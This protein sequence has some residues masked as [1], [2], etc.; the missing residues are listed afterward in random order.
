[1]ENQPPSKR[2]RLS[3]K[4][5]RDNISSSASTSVIS[6][7]E[8]VEHLAE[9]DSVICHAAQTEQSTERNIASSVCTGIADDVQVRMDL[10]AS[11]MKSDAINIDDKKDVFNGPVEHQK[12]FNWSGWTKILPDVIGSLHEQDNKDREITATVI[13]EVKTL[14]IGGCVTVQWI[15]LPKPCYKCLRRTAA[16]F[17]SV[18]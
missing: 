17:Q 3:L 15:P 2:V 11:V 18:Y 1:M 7:P 14:T 5:K 8:K 9:N 13:S 10:S 16:S 12:L 6:R 4:V